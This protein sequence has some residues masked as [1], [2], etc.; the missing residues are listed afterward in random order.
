MMQ[1]QLASHSL[2]CA[3]N[4]GRVGREGN[5]Q[6]DTEASLDLNLTQPNHPP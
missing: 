3:E 6:L 2:R 1:L 4:S 5:S